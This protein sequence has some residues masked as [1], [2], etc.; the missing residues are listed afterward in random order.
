R[1]LVDIAR[2]SYAQTA[3]P[4]YSLRPLPHA[5]VATP[6]TWDEL[7]RT[8]PDRYTIDSVRRRLAQRPDP[9]KDMARHRCGLTRAAR[10][11]AAL[12][13]QSGSSSSVVRPWRT[14]SFWVEVGL[15]RRSAPLSLTFTKSQSLASWPERVRVS[16]K[17]P[18]SLS[19]W[20]STFRCPSSRAWPAGTGEF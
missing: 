12:G 14:D 5:P 8:K 13:A 7:S 17:A 11:L 6:I 16:A 1:V 4:P 20:S 15:R 3:A 2:N 18:L 10:A 19:P 9:W